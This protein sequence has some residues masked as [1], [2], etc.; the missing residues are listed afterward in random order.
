MG[1]PQRKV[2]KPPSAWQRYKDRVEYTPSA[3]PIPPRRKSPFVK[4][5][6][7]FVALVTLDGLG[8]MALK[9]IG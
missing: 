2:T 3:F 9:I 4:L 1:Q 7:D 6:D 5:H 8:W